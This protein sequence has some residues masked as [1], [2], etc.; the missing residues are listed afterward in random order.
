MHSE[1]SRLHGRGHPSTK[2]ETLRCPWRASGFYVGFFKR[3]QRR[4]VDFKASTRA[5]IRPF[6]RGVSRH[7]Q[8]CARQGPRPTQDVWPSETPGVDPYMEK[9]SRRDDAG[10]FSVNFRTWIGS[11]RDARD[12]PTSLNG[13]DTTWMRMRTGSHHPGHTMSAK[14]GDDMGRGHAHPGHG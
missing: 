3:P 7:R 13:K 12:R 14:H 5:R 9:A 1:P 8:A 4:P 6:G 2:R 11:K 10:R